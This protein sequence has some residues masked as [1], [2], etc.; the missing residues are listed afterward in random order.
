MREKIEGHPHYLATWR[1]VLALFVIGVLAFTAGQAATFYKL[2]TERSER[3]AQLNAINS[4]QCNSIRTLKDALVASKRDELAR[5][6][7]FLDLHPQGQDGITPEIVQQGIKAIQR[8]LARL[9]HVGCAVPFVL[10]TS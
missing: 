2:R 5:S 10:P 1:G 8:D 3:L 4:N 6:F 9:Q 7:S